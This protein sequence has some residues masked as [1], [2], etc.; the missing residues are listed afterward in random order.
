MTDEMCEAL[1]AAFIAN[2]TIL[3]ETVT[4]ESFKAI[5]QDVLPPGTPAPDKNLSPE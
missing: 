2:G 3:Q 1:W 5:S 4:Y